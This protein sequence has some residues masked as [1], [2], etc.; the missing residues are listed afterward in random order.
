M[1]GAALAETAEAA[2]YRVSLSAA[3]TVKRPFAGI[4][5]T[6][7]IDDQAPTLVGEVNPDRQHF[8]IDVGALLAPSGGDQLDIGF[9]M[10]IEDERLVVDT[11]DYQQLKDQ[12]PDV[13]L[14]PFEPGIFFVDL[15]EFEE[16]SPEL[17]AAIGGTS[18][19]D[20]REMAQKLPAALISVEETSSDPPTFVGSMTYADLLEA[21][22]GDVG[23]SASGAAAGI[24]LNSA[25][26]ADVLTQFYI[27]FF[28]SVE[29]EVVIEL[30]E[31]GLFPVLSTRSDLSSQYRALL[32]VEGFVPEMTESERHEAFEMFENAVHVLETRAV[33]EVDDDLKVSVPPTTADDRTDQWRQLLTAAGLGT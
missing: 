6:A 33:Y 25:V 5:T 4:D 21:Q 24:A 8:V 28:V 27:D 3:Q 20:L 30:N 15:T 23:A 2:T 11:R 16:D 9:E 18:A 26:S 31:Q 17:L 10:W 29:V 12:N 1:L 14:G 13:Q 22:G 32:D 7:E 19:P